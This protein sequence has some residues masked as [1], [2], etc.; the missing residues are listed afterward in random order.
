M[1]KIVQ[2]QMTFPDTFL[3]S[4]NSLVFKMGRVPPSNVK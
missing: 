1:F 2:V 4:L 3:V